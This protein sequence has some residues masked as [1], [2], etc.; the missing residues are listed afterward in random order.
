MVLLKAII[1]KSW[2]I[3]YFTY[4][5]NHIDKD[6]QKLWKITEFQWPLEMFIMQI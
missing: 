5:K 3:T 1:E 6:N 2:H 4:C